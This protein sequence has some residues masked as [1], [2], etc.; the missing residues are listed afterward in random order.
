M[1]K[2]P[3]FILLLFRDPSSTP[4]PFRDDTAQNVIPAPF[5]SRSELFASATQ[6]WE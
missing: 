5:S 4:T 3:A 6:T 1:I 2:N